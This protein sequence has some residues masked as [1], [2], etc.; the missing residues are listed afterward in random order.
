MGGRVQGRIFGDDGGVRRSVA[1][2]G[3]LVFNPL[4]LVLRLS[5]RTGA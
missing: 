2:D 1:S 3:G 5:P 4:Q